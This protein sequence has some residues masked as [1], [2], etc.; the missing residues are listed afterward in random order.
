MDKLLCPCRSGRHFAQCC[1][2]YLAGQQ[3]AATARVL[4]R[5]RY[6]AYVQQDENYLLQSWHPSTRPHDLA[7]RQQAPV[8]WLGLTIIRT[9]AG[10][11]NDTNGVVEFVARYKV[12]GKAQ[13]LHETSQFVKEAGRWFYVRGEMD[14]GSSLRSSPK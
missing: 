14:D 8:K 10:E 4:M 1:G 9:Q 13:R 11:E 2:P 12:N 6:T 5:S 3:L 7:L